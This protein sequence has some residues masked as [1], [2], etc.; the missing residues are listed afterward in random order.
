[1][2]IY[3]YIY[4]CVRVNILIMY[5]IRCVSSN[6]FF[7]EVF[8]SCKVEVS[9]RFDQCFMLNP[10]KNHPYV[11]TYGGVQVDQ[12]GPTPCRTI[13]TKKVLSSEHFE[14]REA[15]PSEAEAAMNRAK[16]EAEAIGDSVK[17]WMMGVILW[18]MQRANKK[19]GCPTKRWGL[20]VKSLIIMGMTNRKMGFAN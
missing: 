15:L 14:L 5:M 3:I 7:V 10:C 1:M 8:P 9:C 20:P 17:S 6:T 12:V 16:M 18:W 19:V 2:C 13:F 11:G 4:V